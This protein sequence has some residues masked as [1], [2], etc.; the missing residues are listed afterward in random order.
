MGS[1]LLG[2]EASKNSK[3]EIS[4]ISIKQK[5]GGGD[6]GGGVNRGW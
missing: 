4:L 2:L 5:G 1:I 3:E 6:G